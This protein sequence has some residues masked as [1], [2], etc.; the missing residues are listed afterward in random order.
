MDTI[1]FARGVPAPECIA[2]EELADCARTVIEREG[3]SLLSYGPSAGY[4]PLRALI[5]TMVRR[6][7]PAACCSR[8]ARCR[9]SG[10][11][12]KRFARGN[13]VVVEWPTYDRALKVLLGSG[14]S[15][16]AAVVD[17]EGMN[18][19]D[20]DQQLMG[21]SK[22]A[23]VYTIP[24]F[25]NPTGRTLPAD[26]RQQ[27]VQVLGR[28]QI[29]II[30]DD[31]YALIR[32]DGEALPAIFDYTGKSSIY[33]SSFSKTIAPGLRV[34]WMIL[35]EEIAEDLAEEAAST[36]ITPSLLSQ[37]IVHE[38]IARGSFEPNLR[39]MNELIK[40]RRD[41]MLAALE[42]HFSGATWTRPE[43]GYFVWLQVPM[44]TNLAEALERAKGVTAVLGTEFSA[45]ANCMR[46]AYSYASPEEI[47]VGVERLAAAM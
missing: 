9:G 5:A 27:M 35:P 12:A 31:P 1:S 34:G 28:R 45:P 8:T 6:R 21:Q 46:L 33:M 38:F 32:F 23:F 7:I 41:T 42:K 22:P 19:N 24:T 40:L 43:G 44:G 15:L 26:R 4:T 20:L 36:Y 37:A 17:D 3:K 29:M 2:E 18:I 30:E 14:A 13:N 10:S 39:R 25:Q 47:E 16:L 11:L